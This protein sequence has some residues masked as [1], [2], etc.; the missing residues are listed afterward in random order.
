MFSNGQ[1]CS[2][3][4]PFQNPEVLQLVTMR[5]VSLTRYSCAPDDFHD[6]YRFDAIGD[7][8]A[9]PAGREPYSVRYH[10]FIWHDMPP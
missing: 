9:D 2:G 1:N 3:Y 4:G 5:I 8:P 7:Y 6:P 10:I